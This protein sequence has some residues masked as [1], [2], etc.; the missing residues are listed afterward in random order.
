MVESARGKAQEMN[1]RGRGERAE[2]KSMKLLQGHFH[3]C[4]DLTGE[5][6][7]FQVHFFYKKKL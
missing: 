7:Y 2:V 5:S 6:S 1:T 4:S 3:N